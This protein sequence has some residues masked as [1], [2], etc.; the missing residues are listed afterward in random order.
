MI[1]TELIH[2]I[3]ELARKQKEEGLNPQEKKEQKQLRQKYLKGIREKVKSQIE[4]SM[5]K[6]HKSCDC[7]C[8]KNKHS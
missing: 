8:D 1:T 7:G 5:Q 6:H 3:N 2:R 4:E